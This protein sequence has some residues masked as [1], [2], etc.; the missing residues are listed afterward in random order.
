MSGGVA[1]DFSDFAAGSGVLEVGLA[2]AS[3]TSLGTSVFFWTSVLF[4]SFRSPIVSAR[5]SAPST[6]GLASALKA[7]LLG[8]MR[9]KGPAPKGREIEM[10]TDACA[11]I[12]VSGARDSVLEPS[13][14]FHLPMLVS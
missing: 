5:M 3:P 2:V 7:I 4:C 12:M 11:G 8:A 13:A 10:G 6:T 9:V 1:L 14:A